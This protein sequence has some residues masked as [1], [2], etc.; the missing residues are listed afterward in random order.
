MSIS[1]FVYINIKVSLLID[2]GVSESSY[3]KGRSTQS[4]ICTI[5]FTCFQLLNTERKEHSH[6]PATVA[7]AAKFHHVSS[8]IHGLFR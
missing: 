8:S 4:T 1:F 3:G 7:E 2:D 5:A 6:F